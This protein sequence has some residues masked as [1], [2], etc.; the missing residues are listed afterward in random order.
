MKGIIK[1]TEGATAVEFGLI[2]IILFAV[3]FGII[4]FG[5]L[6]YNN[7]MLTHASRVAAREGVLY[8]YSEDTEGN[9]YTHQDD[10]TILLSAETFWKNNFIT[11]GD[12]TT[13]FKAPIVERCRPGADGCTPVT[14]GGEHRN[15]LLTVT[16]TYEYDFLFLRI[17]GIG[18]VNLQA[19]TTMIF[20]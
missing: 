11:F 9:Y 1:N 7:S 12:S 14:Y 20:E 8:A 15:D 10:T 4:E 6:L 13:A 16:L 18:P 3:M 19:A 5:L 2:A 17:F